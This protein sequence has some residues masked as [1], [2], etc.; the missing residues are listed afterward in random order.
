MDVDTHPAG[1]ATVPVVGE[2]DKPAF[3]RIV[4]P[5]TRSRWIWKYQN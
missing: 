2:H 3:E 5:I 4:S 1:Y